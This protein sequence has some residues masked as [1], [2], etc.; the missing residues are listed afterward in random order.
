MS[1]IISNRPYTDSFITSFTGT[2]DKT[3]LDLTGKGEALIHIAVDFPGSR[4]LR[5]A[6]LV[7]DGNTLLTNDIIAYAIAGTNPVFNFTLTWN[8]S[9]FLSMDFNDVGSTAYATIL[10]NNI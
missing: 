3:L 6:S 10:Y 2:T 7:I 1:H 9:I 5:I 8:T 4:D